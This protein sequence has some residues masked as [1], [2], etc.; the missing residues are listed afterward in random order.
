[1]KTGLLLFALFVFVVVALLA[2]ANSTWEARTGE[3]VVR[4]ESAAL[5]PPDSVFSPALLVGLPE[6]VARYLRAVLRDRTVLPW[7][8]LVRQEGTFRA[9]TARSEGW[10]F[11]AEQHY[12]SRPAGFVWDARMRMAPGLDVFVRDAF[13]GGEGSMLGRVA[14]IFP[15]TEAHG[16]GDVAVASLQR[17][18]A[19]TV[20]FPTA[21]LPGQSVAWTAID[22]STA[23][24][25]ATSGGVSASLDFHFGE[26]SLVA[27][28]GTE[29]RARTVGGAAVATPWRGDWKVWRW[30]EGMRIPT[31]GE[32]QWQLPS[33]PFT[34]WRGSVVDVRYH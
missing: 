30:H 15:V 10:A 6:P 14:G 26:D 34:Y 22:D 18:L 21:L 13:V 25:T 27:W 20:W 24:A 28:V 7:H 8:T 19:E 9:D 29:S 1:M 5:S 11:E 32:V 4:L 16:A 2:A 12:D 23:R 31:S 33:G 3:A 17:W